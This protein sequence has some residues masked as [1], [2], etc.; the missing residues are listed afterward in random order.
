MSNSPGGMGH[1]PATVDLQRSRTFLEL[2]EHLG[3]EGFITEHRAYFVR[4]VRNVFEKEGDRTLIFGSGSWTPTTSR[5][6]C[7]CI[8]TGAFNRLIVSAGLVEAEYDLFLSTLELF[9]PEDSDDRSIAD[10][11]SRGLVIEG[12]VSTR[13]IL[14]G[15][16]AMIEEA[17]AGYGIRE[18]SFIMD[19]GGKVICPGLA[20]TSILPALAAGNIELDVVRELADIPEEGGV[21]SIPDSEVR[22]VTG[23]LRKLHPGS[24]VVEY[25]DVGVRMPTPGTGGPLPMTGMD[26][27]PLSGRESFHRPSLPTRADPGVGMLGGLG[28]GGSSGGGGGGSPLSS[29]NDLLLSLVLAEYFRATQKR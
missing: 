15:L 19:G 9:S 11:L 23:S 1:D 4:D 12:P 6:L 29:T 2:S 14:A 13:L 21:I 16:G 25:T 24:T 17:R 10:T 27:N 26:G 8:T 20:H 3:M 18:R 22:A 5:L 7:D 28:G